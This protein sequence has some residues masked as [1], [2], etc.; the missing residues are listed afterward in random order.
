[1]TDSKFCEA[2]GSH[3]N[4]KNYGCSLMPGH[5]GD[6]DVTRELVF[7]RGSLPAVPIPMRLC[8]EGCGK[9]HIDEGEF[10]TKPHHTH[11]CQHCGLTWRPAVVH[12]VGVQF[13]PGFKN[14]EPVKKITVI[15]SIIDPGSFWK[16]VGDDSIVQ[17]EKLIRPVIGDVQ[18]VLR[19]GS[20]IG[21]D[22]FLVHYVRQRDG[23]YGNKSETEPIKIGQ[24]WKHLW[25]TA[26]V[27][28]KEFGTYLDGE[29]KITLSDGSS[30]NE[31]YFR[32]TYALQ[33]MPIAPDSAF[34]VDDY[35]RRKADGRMGLVFQVGSKGDIECPDGG[36]VFVRSIDR[37]AEGWISMW[38]K[39]EEI[40]RWVPRINEQVR[41]QVG[42]HTGRVG[43]MSGTHDELFVVWF[44]NEQGDRFTLGA[45]TPAPPPLSIQCILGGEYVWVEADERD[46]LGDVRLWAL[47]KRKGHSASADTTGNWE[48][49]NIHGMTLPLDAEVKDVPSLHVG[50]NTPTLYINPPVGSGG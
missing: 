31:R 18:V 30:H 28:V 36:R 1:M 45:L 22:H 19:D 15:G 49:R 41:I 50:T 17:V 25:S 47:S 2:G 48:L 46:T 21:R 27:T 7:G 37:K 40:E 24:S 34:K 44:K 26:L 11:S 9:L 14:P 8:C 10:A 12:T 35:V 20:K 32:N 6:C 42:E 38:F 23:L 29:K 39:P 33:G 43:T 4:G 3:I 13:L 5:A 16:R